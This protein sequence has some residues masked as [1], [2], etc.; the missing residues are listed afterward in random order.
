MSDIGYKVCEYRNVAAAFQH[1]L[2]SG[3]THTDVPS[4]FVRLLRM[5][6][7]SATLAVKERLV[8]RA[9]RRARE[10]DRVANVG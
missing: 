6:T 7:D 9:A 3:L 8:L 2:G 10:R 4:P 1:F 5:A